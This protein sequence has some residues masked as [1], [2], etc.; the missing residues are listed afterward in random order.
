MP[1]TRIFRVPVESLKWRTKSEK[2]VSRAVQGVQECTGAPRQHL[3]SGFW[4]LD[5]R[6]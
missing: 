4:F 2:P 3:V 6:L 5:A 1:A